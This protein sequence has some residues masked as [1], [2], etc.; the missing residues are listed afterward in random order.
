[1]MEN[2][3]ITGT[4]INYFFVCHRKLWL[5]THDISMEHG[6]E[7]VR[8][9][10]LL[11]EHSYERKRK[12]LELDGIKIDFYD[13][14]RGCI[15]E[16]KKSKAIEKSHVW[17]LKYYLYYFKKAGVNIE[18]EIDYPLIRKKEKIKLSE[19]DCREIEVI[20]DKIKRILKSNSLPEPVNRPFCRKCSYYD[21]CFI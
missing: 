19:D 2:I 3:I 1:M 18:G 7:N 5:F 11:H 15:H 13:K 17:Q 4:Q 9:G 10:F 12:E 6:S 8:I 21:L 20:L 14:N 16:V